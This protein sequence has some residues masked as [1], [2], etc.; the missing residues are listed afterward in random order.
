MKG[1]EGLPETR[2][3]DEINSLRIRASNITEDAPEKL[4]FAVLYITKPNEAQL[5]L[6]VL[7]MVIKLV[8]ISS[9]LWKSVPAFPELLLTTQSILTRIS[10]SKLFSSLPSTA[11]VLSSIPVAANS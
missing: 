3:C 2:P 11:K 10:K 7:N 4:S 1:I 6:Q 5:K 9:A 8:D